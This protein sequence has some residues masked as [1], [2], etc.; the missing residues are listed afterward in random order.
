MFCSLKDGQKVFY[1]VRG[2]PEGNAILFLSGLSQST[3]DW[4]SLCAQL[5]DTY[6]LVLMDLVFQ[7]Q[8]DKSGDVRSIGQHADN[9]IEL[10]DH[11]HLETVSLV[12]ISYGSVVSQNLMVH[13]PQRL[14]KIALL[15]TLANNTARFLE[16]N[17]LWSNTLEQNG[18]QSMM[19]LVFPFSLGPL[20]FE[21]PS[22]PI[23]QIKEMGL[24][25]NEGQAVMKLMQGL[26]KDSFYESQL[27]EINLP[28]LVIHGEYDF[29]CLPDMGRAVAEAIPGARFEL[30]KGVGHT[31]NIEA[32]PQL[33]TLLK[34]F[35]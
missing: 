33:S 27:G 29:L 2:N 17:N 34:E 4:S 3:Q 24:A 22:M 31:L 19:D 10:L 7:G 6:H 32:I 28:T 23:P 5:G 30:I 14:E 1:E 20:F 21:T 11:L 13:Y 25:I 9:V 15:S 12:G 26:A 16:I 8:S 18:L 35:L